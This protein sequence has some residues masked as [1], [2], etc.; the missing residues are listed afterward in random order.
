R[1]TEVP[2]GGGGLGT[3]RRARARQFPPIQASDKR[4]PCCGLVAVNAPMATH[5][6]AV[7]ATAGEGWK[8]MGRQ[9]RRSFHHSD[10]VLDRPLHLLQ[11]ADLDL[12]HAFTRHA[13]LGGQVPERDRIVGKPA[14]L[15][16]APL[17]L[18]E[19]RERFAE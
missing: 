9:R 15:E 17:A 16:D 11:G 7:S 4:Y 3:V 5:T 12:A 13:E 2:A 19:R 8:L 18:V 6:S 1:K 14:G 10:V